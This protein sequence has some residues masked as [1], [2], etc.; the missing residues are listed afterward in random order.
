MVK[1]IDIIG[2][3]SAI[4]H[5][6]GLKVYQYLIEEI[7]R[8]PKVVVS[9]AGLEHCTTSFLNASIGKLL[10]NRPEV[11]D[12]ISYVDADKMLQSKIERVQ[13]NALNESLRQAHDQSVRDYFEA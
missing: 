11:V 12:K 5:S 2:K 10:M 1:I 9:F 6:D 3:S 13:Y 8:T 4:L 7:L